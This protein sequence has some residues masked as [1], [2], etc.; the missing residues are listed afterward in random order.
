MLRSLGVLLCAAAAA[1]A[2][3]SPALPAQTLLADWYVDGKT[4]SD[5]PTNGMSAATPWKTITYA[6]TQIPRPAQASQYQQL[7]VEGNQ[8]YSPS[9]NG[10][11]LP[12][13]P[14]YNVSIEGTFAGH[15]V[16]P[17]IQPGTGGTSIA[18]AANETFNRNQVTLR[19]LVFDGGDYGATMGASP[20]ARHRPRFQECR[21][22]SQARAGVQMRDVGNAIADP[23]FFQNLFRG[24][25]IGIEV[26]AA[27]SAAIVFPDIEECSFVGNTTAGV[28]LDDTSAGGANVG[29][30]VRSNW[31]RNCNRG[32]WVT[33]GRQAATTNFRVFSS[34]FADIAQEAVFLDVRRSVDPDA[35][36]ERSS[37][38]RCGTG[39]RFAGTMGEGAYTLALRGNFARSCG[40]AFLTSI[41]GPGPLAI[42]SQD[43]LAEGCGTGYRVDV[44][45]STT[46]I[47]F[48][49]L[50][51]R[52]MRNDVGFWTSG[53]AAASSA[54]SVQSA[55][56]C[57]N[58][59]A[60]VRL[61]GQVATTLRSAT[62]ADNGTGLDVVATATTCD[63]LVFS[64]N[65]T[66]ASGAP[67]LTYSCFHG[68][69]HPGIGNLNLTDPQLRRPFYKLAPSSPCIDVGNVAAALP[70]TDYEGDPRAAVSKVGGQPRPDLGADEYVL[71]GSVRKYGTA[72]FGYLNFFPEIDSPST[73]AIIGGAV[74]VDLSGAI[75]P[76]FNVPANGAL[77]TLGLRDDAGMLPRE[78]GPYG[79]PGSLVW[80]DIAAVLGTFPVSPTGTAAVTVPI[81][82]LGAL[83]GETFTFQ[84]YALIPAA[85]AV[86]VATSDG[87]RVTIGR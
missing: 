4:G 70:A 31:F 58:S 79:A 40:T 76:V 73:Q 87:L 50:R 8:V 55:M 23:R 25:P 6:L 83:I 35:T 2:L 46:V 7:Y 27:S 11:T 80:N 68:S 37:F 34:S 47:A 75:L 71:T 84:W 10:E 42:T 19:Y 86:G 29:A 14:A 39:V 49:S 85:N 26:L 41:D 22:E 62:L 20:G 66:D 52:A 21:F 82:P 77:L 59:T 65:T 61:N 38:L 9:T 28:R 74:R 3:S 13:R 69:T 64:G 43:N 51:D 16:M 12:I 81:P 36:I 78:L 5:L 60:G 54:F 57:G 63:H 1:A 56:A 30:N 45:G 15:G 53:S 17:R 24:A 33:V 18:F 48:R 32:V 44:T 72:G 67:P